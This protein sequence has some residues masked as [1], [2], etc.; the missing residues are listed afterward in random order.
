MTVR[1]RDRCT[2]GRE[3]AHAVQRLQLEAPVIL[4]LP[5]GGVPVAYEIAWKL[6]APLDLVLVRK[7][8][9]P[10]R[11]EFGMGAIA[12]G[13]NPRAYLDHDLIRSLG[14]SD[15]HIQQEI[16]RQTAEME[17]RRLTYLGERPPS[18]VSGKHVVLV[19][20][21]IATGGTVRVALDALRTS[22]AASITLAVPVAPVEALSTFE[23]LVDK[24]IC[25]SFPEP[26]V[27]VGNHYERFDQTTDE[28][29]IDLLAQA[30]LRTGTNH[31]AA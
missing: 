16:T 24:M 1:F 10:G 27:A 20:D 15:D 11:P 26:F 12:G 21:G 25:L 19:D 17:R 2:A 8:G 13:A 14:I 28:E 3:L 6:G 9:V 23:P 29:V 31:D 22:T 18:D 30:H 4:A 5:R 7:L